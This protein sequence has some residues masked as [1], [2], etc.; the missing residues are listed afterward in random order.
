VLWASESRSTETAAR[1][2][3]HGLEDTGALQ[4]LCAHCDT[5]L[6]VCPP[7]A[8]EAQAEAVLA[9]GF[10]GRYVDANAISPQ[11][12]QRMAAHMASAGIDVVDG[13]IIGGPAWTPGKTVL[14]L[15]GKNAPAIA[16]LFAGS[17]LATCMLGENI[18]DASALKMCYTAVSKGTTALLAAV[19]TTAHELGVRQALQDLWQADEAGTNERYARRIAAAAPKAW[20]WVGEMHEIGD[21]L[22]AAGLPRNFHDG[23]AEVYRRMAKFKGRT[24]GADEALKGLLNN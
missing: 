10:R 6:S 1:A 17:P 14:A 4:A 19:L 23:A 24:P 9:A 3:R 15:S 21:T 7:Y 5:L 2:A 20:R 8:A 11:R 16:A 18:G 13:G 22:A 12:M